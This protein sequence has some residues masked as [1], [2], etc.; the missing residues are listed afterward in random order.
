MNARG[1]YITAAAVLFC[2]AAALAQSGKPLR[3]LVY[4]FDFSLNQDMTVEDSGIAS[5]GGL[6]G[7]RVGQG[8][9]I[10]HY[11]G[12]HG[13]KGTITVD[14]MTVQPDAGLVLYIAEQARESRSAA[15]AMCVVYGTGSVIC[16]PNK[17]IN[18]EEMA[19]LRVL[20]RN[21]INPSTMD[22]RR[23]W[24]YAEAGDQGKETND[25][26]IVSES[27]GTYGISYQRVLA[28]AGS[29][30]YTATTYGQM[31]YNAKSS[32]PTL[33]KEETITR[34]NGMS[35]ANRLDQ[36]ITLSLASDTMT[37]AKAP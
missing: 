5:G 14:V 24:R 25:F 12:G 29:Q 18:E 33:I 27:G 37:A 15:S 1:L 13:D 35:Q 31:T 20:G 21:F 19:L 16:D 2:T 23:H 6:A 11:R 17:K 34:E 30:P 28:V 9:G 10:T 26:T 32:A 8:T 3:H 4:A 36:Q 22:A 7:P